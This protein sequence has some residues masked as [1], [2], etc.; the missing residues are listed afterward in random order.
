MFT[1][2]ST[3]FLKT[4]IYIFCSLTAIEGFSQLTVQQ[5][6]WKGLE[7]TKASHLFRFV[8]LQTGD[9]Y[10][11]SLMLEDE[12]QIRNL[13]SILNVTG[14]VDS[15]SQGVRITYEVEEAITFFPIVNFGGLRDNVW[16]QLGATEQNML[17]KGIQTTAFY[18]NNDN[19][20]NGQFHL[21]NPYLRGSRWGASFGLTNWASVEPLFFEGGNTVYYLYD[22][23]A[24]SSSIIR[25]M[26]RNHFVELGASYFVESYKKHDRH[27]GE[28]TPGPNSARLPKMLYKF[29]HSLD[30]RN[31]HYYVITG[32]NLTQHVQFVQ[33][34]TKDDPLFWM[35]WT[36]FN[37]YWSG[38]HKK[39]FNVASRLRFGLA[40]NRDSPF[41]PFVLDSHVNI[42]GAG[43][44]IDRGT[45][46]FVWN[47]ELRQTLFDQGNYA[48]QGVAFSDFGRWRKPGGG[49]DDLFSEKTTQHFYGIGLRLIYKK[50]HNAILRADYGFNQ[51]DTRN[52][53]WVLGIGQYF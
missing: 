47:V 41:A 5:I 30:K 10:D 23:R 33:N 50:M 52:N 34:L 19:R 32:W 31:Y 43:N 9:N 42:R 36:D 4:F 1:S 12:Q 48:A 11:P 37:Y 16:V 26:K 20:H 22:N 38:P 18:Q 45:G 28:I 2:F 3:K 15:T 49:F 39:W 51:K 35:S 25:E 13:P 40:D 24:V 27:E 8:E 44:R 7:R 46:T 14:Q 17:G 29:S 21:R 6:D 53:G